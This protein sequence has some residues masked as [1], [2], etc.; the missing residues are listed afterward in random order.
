MENIKLA[1]IVLGAG[2]EFVDVEGITT[3]VSLVFKE[4]FLIFHG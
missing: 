4:I 1:N 3:A 2:P